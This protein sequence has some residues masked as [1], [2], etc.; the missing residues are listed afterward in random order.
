MLRLQSQA[1]HAGWYGADGGTKCNERYPAGAPKPICGH[2]SVIELDGQMP[3]KQALAYWATG[4]EQYAHN[5]FEIINSWAKVSVLLL[6]DSFLCCFLCGVYWVLL[7]G[8]EAPQPGGSGGVLCSCACKRGDQSLTAGGS[9]GWTS[10]RADGQMSYKQASAYWAT[11]DEQ[12]AHNAFDIINSWAKVRGF[13][14]SL[15]STFPVW[16]AMYA[17]GRVRGSGQ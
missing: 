12:Y 3:Y 16:F 9:N 13:L 10:R 1:V 4:D 8:S 15:F 2:V 7:G 11:G 17:A 6:S 14:C 5:A